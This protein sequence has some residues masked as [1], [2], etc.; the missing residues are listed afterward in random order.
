[1]TD[2]QFK[3]EH[4]VMSEIAQTYVD[5]YTYRPHEK[6]REQL[7]KREAL[8]HAKLEKVLAAKPA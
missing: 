7:I 5:L 1:M 8:L 2:E 3:Q 4:P 6:T